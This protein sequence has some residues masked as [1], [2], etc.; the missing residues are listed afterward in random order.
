MSILHFVYMYGHAR[1]R[2]L[3]A[4]IICVIRVARIYIRNNIMFTN[5]A[6]ATVRRR[7]TPIV[8]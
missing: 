7:A 6:V 3:H 1:D 2:T 8:Y 4:S 5:S